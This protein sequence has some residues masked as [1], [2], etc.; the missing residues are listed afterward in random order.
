[1]EQM[2]SK[3]PPLERLIDPYPWI[4]RSAALYRE[5]AIKRAAEPPLIYVAHPVAPQ[6][7]ETLATCS[8]CKAQRTYRIHE[9]VDLRLLCAHDAPVRHTEEERAIVAFN[10][11]RARRWWAWLQQLHGASWIMPWVVNVEHNGDER[12]TGAIERGLRDDCNVVRRC[13]ALM[14]CGPRISSGMAREA[15]AAHEAKIPVFQV[16]GFACEPPTRHPRETMWLEKWA[17]S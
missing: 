4:S 2:E 1:M 5:G 13:D 8:E 17:P 11:A 3:E 7:G 16:R 15:D 12:D 9:G 14:L 10:V 6:R